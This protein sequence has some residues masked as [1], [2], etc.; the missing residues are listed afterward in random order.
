MELDPLARPRTNLPP[1][2]AMEAQFSQ[3]DAA[4]VL[5]ARAHRSQMRKG[6]DIPYLVHPVHVSV[7]LIRYGFPD[8]VVLAG[9]L[10]DVVEDQSVS[11]DR[12]EM[13]FG[14]AVAEMVDAL[15]ERKLEGGRKRPWEL[16]KREAL[17]QLRTA[18]TGA[19]AVKA[20]DVLH[21]ARS[22]AHL[23][24][25]EG[26]AAWTHYAGGPEQ[27]VE[28]YRNV[29]ALARERLGPHPLVE[30]VKGAIAD[31]EGVIAEQETA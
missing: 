2:D 9:L 24:R 25:C 13:G 20:A 17:D 3:Y 19:V 18:S 15:T 30:G 11:P 28:Y 1:E 21:N 23:L 12:I 8:E 6:S 5:A 29:A 4:L 16:R 31:L 7:L 26:A 22:L 10:H 27:T 14:P